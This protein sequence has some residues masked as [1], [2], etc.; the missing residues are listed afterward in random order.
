MMNGIKTIRFFL[1]NMFPM[2]QTPQ[3]Y[4]IAFFIGAAATLLPAGFASYLDPEV[5]TQYAAFMHKHGLLILV[6]MIVMETK[7]TKIYPTVLFV[8]A[9]ITSSLV[10]GF[11]SNTGNETVNAIQIIAV[12]SSATMMMVGM[13]TV[14]IIVLGLPRLLERWMRCKMMH[15]ILPHM[16]T[17]FAWIENHGI[18]PVNAT[19]HQII[20]Y[21]E[22]AK[23]PN[24]SYKVPK[25]L[26]HTQTPLYPLLG[27][28]IEEK[29]AVMRPCRLHQADV[30][31]SPIPK[32]IFSVKWN[33][34]LSTS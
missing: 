14:S 16:D 26:S 19:A 13:Y 31:K 20:R 27:I 6:C 25:T 2:L 33:K 32:P 15:R 5:S 30:Q 34:S 28:F 11:Y 7:M 23:N 9:L 4:S 18:L 21:H 1:S 8:S 24:I 3:F 29:K 17:N 22:K 12:T 10:Y